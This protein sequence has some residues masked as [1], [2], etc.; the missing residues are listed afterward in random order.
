MSCK[1]KTH[2][3]VSLSEGIEENPITDSLFGVLSEKQQYYQHFLI[4]IP[5]N[6][7][8]NIDSLSNWILDVQPGGLSFVNWDLDSVSRL[9]RKLDTLDLIQPFICVDY[10]N[11][12]NIDSYPFW[13]ASIENCDLKWTKVFSNDGVSMIDF[14][15]IEKS[16][17]FYEWI[18]KWEEAKGKNFIVNHYEDKNIKLEFQSFITDL[19]TTHNALEIDLSILDTVSLETLRNAYSF[20]GVFIVSTQKRSINQQIEN[21]AD[22]I[23]VNAGQLDLNS[24]PYEDWRPNQKN[25]KIVEESTKRILAFKQKSNEITANK[26]AKE[27]VLSVS[28]NLFFNSNVLLKNESKIIP[29]EA[30]VKIY[31]EVKISI[32]STLRKENEFSIKMSSIEENLDQI[33]NG[34]GLK[35][36]FLNDTISDSLAL[37]ICQVEK[38][39]NTL[40]CFSNSNNYWRLKDTPNLI[41]LNKSKKKESDYSII[42]QQLTG[43]LAFN[44]NLPFS[45]TLLTGVKTKKIKLART[46]PSFCSVSADSLKGIDWAIRSAIN[47]NAFPGC[48]V[49]IAKDG[50]VFYDKSFGYHTYDRQKPV[51][52]ESLYDVASLT[53]VVATTMVGMKLFEMGTYQ[54]SDSLKDFL[55]D[56]LRDYLPY[57]S[58]IRN[59]TFQEL[60]THSS[61]LPAG[62]P[63]LPYMQYTTSEIGRFDKFYCDIKDSVYS[64]EVAEN[65]FLEKCYQ[66]SMWLKLNQIWLDPSKQYRYSDVNMNTLYFIFKSILQGDPNKYGFDYTTDELKA[67]NLFVEFLYDKVYGPLGMNRTNYKPLDNFAKTEIVPTEKENFWRKQLLHG[68]VHD[69]NA[70]LYGGIAGNAGIFS[71]THDLAIL[72]E[73]L[74]RK[75]LYNGQ[76]Y[77]SAETVNKFS[78]SQPNSFRGLGFNKPSLNT[79]AFGCADDA[80]PETFGHTGFTGTCIWIDPVNKI[81]YVFLSNRVNPSVNNR[82]YQYGIRANIHQMAYDARLFE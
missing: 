24:L 5:T 22:L 77:F 11:Y 54:L 60:F 38:S 29:F 31:S 37:R 13:D 17:I 75:G 44:G 55:P 68:H 78:S 8:N 51:T 43:Q 79:S 62:F 63:V 53:K 81:T 25:Q 16:K 10:F 30:G 69:P 73:M 47:G 7:Q 6:Y 70:A 18:A 36:V 26:S 61:G 3:S 76:R 59:I 58:T 57:P 50:C 40:F 39:K 42:L 23:R 64:I 52:S 4:E 56:T 66:D 48:Q 82:I 28:D 71:T 49:I 27:Q 9:K 45:D 32:G 1:E 35:L 33:I 80:A 14:G 74:L 41:F 12:L 19:K 20:T 2:P 72:A 34:K 15:R 21:G 46:D 67:K 65:L